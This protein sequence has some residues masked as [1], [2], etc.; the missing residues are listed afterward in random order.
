VAAHLSFKG[1]ANELHLS[2]SALT[3]QIQALEE[4]VGVSLFLRL[5]PGLE[6]TDAGREYLTVVRRVLSDLDSA[7]ARLAPRSGPLRISAL[8]S[9]VSNWL[10]PNLPDFEREHPGVELKI[11]AAFRYA[12]FARDPVDVAI[13]F[14][15]GPWG[16]L[17]NQPLLDLFVDPLCARSLLT[18]DPPLR[19][20][21][22]LT[23]HTLIHISQTPNAWAHWLL[24][25]GAEGLDP[26]R[27]LTFDHVGIALSAAESGQGVVLLPDVLCAQRIEAGRLCR[28]FAIHHRSAATYHFV[29][30]PEEAEQ[31]QIQALRDW[32]LRRLSTFARSAT[33]VDE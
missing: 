1:A 32:L 10:V 16:E 30:R 15:T 6:L 27:S 28:P 13:R 29:C 8:E 5:N 12:D 11:E 31:P 18:G 25:A 20:P 14:G 23:G 7:R 19:T 3:R 17:Y 33:A 21:S 24:A 22:D 9:F 2:P 4:H 26:R